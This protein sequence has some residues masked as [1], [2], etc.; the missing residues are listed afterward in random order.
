M[1]ALTYKCQFNCS[2]CAVSGYSRNEKEL[3][4]GEIKNLIDQLYALKVPR[5]YFEGGEPL[6]RQD[7][8]DIVRLCSR[9]GF[10]T[11]LETNGGLLTKEKVRLLKEAG[12]SCINITFYSREEEMHDKFAGVKDAFA[13]A[14]KALASC[15]EE[16]IPF[17]VSIIASKSLIQNNGIIKIISLAKSLKAG[18][19]RIT[20][21]HFIGRW[22]EL[23][24]PF[25]EDEIKHIEEISVLWPPVF[26]RVPLNICAIGSSIYISASGEL[27]PCE[28]IPYSFGNI[29]DKPVKDILQFMTTHAMFKGKSRCRIDEESFRERYICPTQDSA[30]PI[31]AYF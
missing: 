21:P 24:S 15:R 14:L 19:I 8:D 17:L 23:Y 13:G 4:L 16:G 10:I 28:F 20:A 7:I 18:A 9:K 22:K 11:I 29:K 6:L 1:L 25:S 2:H 31:K 26:K 30:L 27:Q 12:L 5:I 3:T